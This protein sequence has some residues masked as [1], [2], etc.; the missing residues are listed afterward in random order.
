MSDFR[1]QRRTMDSS[2][3]NIQNKRL[4]GDSSHEPLVGAR[5]IAPPVAAKAEL[6]EQCSALRFK[7]PMRDSEVVET[8]HEPCGTGV[9]PVRFDSHRRDACAT[10]ALRK[11]RIAEGRCP[12]LDL[13]S[14]HRKR[15]RRIRASA[16][17]V[18]CSFRPPYGRA[19]RRR[20]KRYR[21]THTPIRWEREQEITR[22]LFWSA[23]SLFSPAAVRCWRNS[24]FPSLLARCQTCGSPAIGSV[25]L[26]R[27]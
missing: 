6:A 23:R 4:I 16:V 18:G 12:R 20:D 15:V 2:M 24:V 19:C 26:V 21:K 27:V 25:S 1:C 9:S 13:N 5:S 10:T 7:V 14:V 17:I 22:R 3:Q 11:M 8:F